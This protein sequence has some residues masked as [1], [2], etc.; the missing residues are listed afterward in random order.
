M[1]I[2]SQFLLLLIAIALIPLGSAMLLPLYHYFTSPQRYLMKGYNQV[3]KLNETNLS[4]AQLEEILETIKGVPPNMKIAIYSEGTIIISNISD[5]K[6]GTKV[7]P[8]DLFGYI[9]QN[10][11][12]YDY[13]IQGHHDFRSHGFRKS[14]FFIISQLPYANTKNKR[15]SNLLV[16]IF[17][18]ILFFEGLCFVIVISLS[19]TVFSS[20]QLLES[21]TKR[22]A[23][24]E[25]DTQLILPKKKNEANEI[26][27]LTENLEQMRASLKDNQE[28]RNKFIMGISHDL[29]TPVALIKGYSEAISDGVVCDMDSIKKSV[30]IVQ[31]KAEQLEVMVNDL[32]N[33]MKLN[34]TEW[35]QH[36]SKVKIKPVLDEFA[37]SA[38][39]TAFAYSRTISAKV[40]VDENTIV[41]MDK[42]LFNRA[43]EN[44]F[45][46]ALRYTKD[47]DSIDI[48][49]KQENNRITIS[50][51]DSGI[52]IAEEDLVH[53]YDMFY[54]GTSSRR[55]QGMGIGLSVVK[56]VIDSHGW[57]IDVESKV[58]EGSCFLITI[59]LP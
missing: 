38:V 42:N 28:R 11:S 12:D 1:K 3:R 4:D 19:R 25:L 32:I 33:Y 35:R 58:G 59:P 9:S 10:S 18:S 20:I 2:K 50:I 23:E 30:S 55:E 7:H 46:N 27:S 57:N 22:I 43:L 48:A 15:K 52:G 14:G 54:R 6:A 21:N 17:I 29:R 37:S 34:T 24:G 51:K 49:A 47:E 31:N 45:S 44:I 39:E 53:I 5:L 13:Q 40:D 8:E 36:L 41:N 26:T 56:T 16:Q